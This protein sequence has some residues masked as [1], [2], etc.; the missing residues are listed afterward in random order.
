MKVKLLS[1]TQNPEQ[2]IATA[3]KLCYSGSNIEELFEAQSIDK[4]EKFIDMLSSLGH[5]SPFE[6]VSFTFA[7]EGVSRITEQ[8]LTRHRLASYSIQSGRYVNRDTASFYIPPE[9]KPGTFEYEVYTKAI[10]Q[11]KKNY[12]D[13]VVVLK[14]KFIQQGMK[15]KDAEKKACENARGIFPNSLETKIIVTMNV[16]SLWNFFKHRCCN[17][18]QEEIKALA[19]EMLKQ[20]KEV[21]PLLFKYAGASCISGICPESKMQCH[22]MKNCIPTMDEVKELIDNY[23]KKQG[24]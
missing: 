20:C 6:H 22:Q 2:V 17:R 12:N 9:I 1:Y 14:Q 13:I 11:S 19:K 10:E 3:A 24:R 16:R 8:Q 5:E 21:A 4:I 23:Y 18:A 15:E 7:I